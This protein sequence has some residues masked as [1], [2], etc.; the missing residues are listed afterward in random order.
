MTNYCAS[1][2]EIVNGKETFPPCYF[3]TAENDEDAKVQA[4]HYAKK[5][6]QDDNEFILLSVCEFDP[7]LGDDIRTVWCP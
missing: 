1:Y 4:E 3:Y 6:K 2:S 5:M 7:E